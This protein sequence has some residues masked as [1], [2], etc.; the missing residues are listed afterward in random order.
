MMVY[1]NGSTD[2]LTVDA[3]GIG[4]TTVNGGSTQSVFQGVLVGV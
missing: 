1:M 3:Y 2:Y 4:L